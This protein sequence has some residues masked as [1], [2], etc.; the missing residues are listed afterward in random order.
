MSDN[1]SFLVFR[2]DCLETFFV[3]LDLLNFSCLRATISKALGLGV[4]AGAAVVK[5]PQIHTIVVRGSTPDAGGVYGELLSAV[6]GGVWN[7]QAGNPFS[8]FGELLILALSNLLVVLALWWRRFPGVAH[9]GLATAAFAAIVGGAVTATRGGDAPALGLD[10]ERA[11]RTLQ[12]AANGTFLLARLSQVSA[13]VLRG[14]VEAEGL[15]LVSLLL[16]FA[17]SAARVFTT[18]QEVKDRAQLLFAVAGAF[19][20][21]VVLVQ[22]LALV[23]LAS[24]AGGEAAPDAKEGARARGRRGGKKEE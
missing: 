15:A 2:E 9:A 13:I 24:G 20:N 7:V 11:L 8:S 16:Q 14:R 10:A 3:H 1:F 22:F 18:L 6:L 21:G 23:T 19:L 17:G 4:I 12:V 5:L